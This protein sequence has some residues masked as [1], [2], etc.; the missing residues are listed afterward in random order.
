MKLHVVTDGI[1]T[2]YFGSIATDGPNITHRVAVLGL[3]EYLLKLV[4]FLVE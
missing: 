3:V 1:V 4:S 2:T